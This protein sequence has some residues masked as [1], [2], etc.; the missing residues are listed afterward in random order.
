MTESTEGPSVQE[1]LGDAMFNGSLKTVVI[2]AIDEE[3]HLKVWHSLDSNMRV[4]G[5]LE[6]A[7]LQVLEVKRE[8]EDGEDDQLHGG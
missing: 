7:K 1:L 2:V 4:A 5:L 6:A 8:E 3:S